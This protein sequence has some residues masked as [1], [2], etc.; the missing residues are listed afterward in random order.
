MVCKA[1]YLIIALGFSPL[2]LKAQERAGQLSISEVLLRPTYLSTEGLG[3]KFSLSDSQFGVGWDMQ[4]HMRARF[5]VGSL[6]QRQAP[7]YYQ[8][9]E[10]ADQI[11][12]VEAYGEYQGIYGKV[13]MGLMPL[14]MGYENRVPDRELIFPDAQI[15]SQRIVARRDYGFSFY[16]GHNGYFTEIMA[17]NGEGAETNDDGNIWVTSRWGWS[18]DRRTHVQVSAQ[19]GRTEAASTNTSGDT[20]IAGFDKSLSATWRLTQLTL[21]WYPRKWDVILEGLYGEVEQKEF[22]NQFESYRLDVIHRISSGF[23]MGLRYDYLDRNKKLN[24]DAESVSSL[25]LIFGGDDD[26]SRV[27]L[28]GSKKTEEGTELPNDELR[29]VWRIRPYF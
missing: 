14:P 5:L 9:T 7:L 22:Q 2:V 12:F 20:S 24:D 15:Y 6:T 29:L 21:H 26:T 11:G 4:P 16:T 10:A 18:D 1:L 23:G 8:S 28:I 19:A 25:A 17:H 27:Y 3:G 13:A